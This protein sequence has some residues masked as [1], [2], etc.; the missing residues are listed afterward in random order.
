MGSRCG[1]DQGGG[2]YSGQSHIHVWISREEQMGT[3]IDRATKD[4][5]VEK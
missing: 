1:E 5:S 4:S 2:W 3:E